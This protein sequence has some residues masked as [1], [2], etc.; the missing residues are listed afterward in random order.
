MRLAVVLI[1]FSLIF[2]SC[3]ISKKEL[4]ILENNYKDELVKLDSQL[5]DLRKSNYELTLNNYQKQGSIATF[6]FVQKSLS[7]QA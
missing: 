6:E 3:G 2:S 4:L 7:G 1:L 5:V